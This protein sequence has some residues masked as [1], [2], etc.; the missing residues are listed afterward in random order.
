MC[1]FVFDIGWPSVLKFRLQFSF[2]EKSK[3]VFGVKQ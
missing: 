1:L 3:M 2:S